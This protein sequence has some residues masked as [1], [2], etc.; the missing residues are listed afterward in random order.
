MSDKKQTII[1]LVGI[2]VF[3]GL[4]LGGIYGYQRFYGGK[5]GEKCEEHLGCMAHGVCISH[6]CQKRC[7]DDKDCDAGYHCG[8]TAVEVVRQQP[9]SKD[10]VTDSTEKIC[11]AN[12]R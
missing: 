9:L 5:I 2:L 8:T 10:A 1:G 7:D 12:K 11:F 3:I 4:V 6:R